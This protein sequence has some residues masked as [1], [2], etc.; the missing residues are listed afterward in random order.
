MKEYKSEVL[1]HLMPTSQTN[2]LHSLLLHPL[3]LFYV[4]VRRLLSQ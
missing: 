4:S 2:A 1:A 3:C